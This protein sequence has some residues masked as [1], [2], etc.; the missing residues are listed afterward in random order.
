MGVGATPFIVTSKLE[1]CSRFALAVLREGVCSSRTLSTGGLDGEKNDEGQR[2]E[3]EKE[4]IVEPW[5]LASIDMR[6]VRWL[7]GSRMCYLVL[8]APPP[9]YRYPIV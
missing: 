5:M 1:T 6:L 8:E 3:E 9:I 7:V 2:R 4:H